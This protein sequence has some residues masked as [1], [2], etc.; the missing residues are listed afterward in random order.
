MLYRALS[1]VLFIA[2]FVCL[3]F[4]TIYLLQYV[5]VGILTLAWLG[6]GVYLYCLLVE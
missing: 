3:T 1:F 6:V 4:L 5:V 2:A